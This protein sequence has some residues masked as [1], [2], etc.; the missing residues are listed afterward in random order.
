M[1]KEVKYQKKPQFI[2]ML[3]KKGGVN[4]RAIQRQFMSSD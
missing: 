2:T 4:Y 3:E 1:L